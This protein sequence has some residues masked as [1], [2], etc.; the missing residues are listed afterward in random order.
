VTSAFG[1]WR[2]ARVRLPPLK[3][4][5]RIKGRNVLLV[6]APGSA[7]TYFWMANIGVARTYPQ[8]A[9]LE[10]TNTA[11]GGSFGSMLMQ[12]LR[13]KSG[14]TYSVGSSFRRG[15]V[16]GEFAISSFTQTDS[17]VQAVDLALATLDTLKQ[18]GASEPAIDSA[19][20]YLLGQYP[21]GFET[22]AD[23]AAAL[24]ELDLYGLPESYIDGFDGALRTVD[25]AQSRQVIDGAFPDSDD[26][27]MVLIGDAARIRPQAARYGA[28]REKSLAAPDFSPPVN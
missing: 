3:A 9:A 11:F 19:R 17:T 10:I 12:A 27:A 5:E 25:G 6:D 23:W 13:V 15:T 26:L 28:L 21:L 7:Q 8:R 1:G 20:S 14:L 4:P 18:H 24:A 22:A 2:P 16:P